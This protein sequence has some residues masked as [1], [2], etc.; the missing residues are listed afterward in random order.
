VSDISP[1]EDL[2]SIYLR[3]ALEINNRL[4]Q[5]LVLADLPDAHVR[6]HSMSDGPFCS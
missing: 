3:V 1:T 2:L 5:P 4:Y 6:I